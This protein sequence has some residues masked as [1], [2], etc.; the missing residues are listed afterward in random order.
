M[1]RTAPDT[2]TIIVGSVIT[3][4][5]LFGALESMGDGGQWAQGGLLAAII[6][7]GSYAIRYTNDTVR[8]WVSIALGI[9]AGLLL[10]TFIGGGVW[11]VMISFLWALLG[12]MVLVSGLP[13]PV[14]AQPPVLSQSMQE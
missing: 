7:G 3:G 14:A 10:M 2:T 1:N 6:A 4:M 5:W 9:F 11:E 13:K 8:T 12:L